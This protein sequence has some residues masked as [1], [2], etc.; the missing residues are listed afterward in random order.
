LCSVPGDQGVLS[1]HKLNISVSS[2]S[3]PV[4]E[5]PEGVHARGGQ[6]AG[7]VVYV[8]D[9]Y[10]KR[11]ATAPMILTLP[12]FYDGETLL[13]FYPFEMSAWIWRPKENCK[14]P[15]WDYVEV[16][17]HGGRGNNFM[18]AESYIK[19]PFKITSGTC[20]YAIPYHAY[21]YYFRV[22]FT[23][24]KSKNE[25]FL[26]PFEEGEFV[27][28][29][30][31]PTLWSTPPVRHQRDPNGGAAAA[32]PHDLVQGSFPSEVG[33]CAPP[34][35]PMMDLPALV[36]ASAEIQNPQAIRKAGGM[37][38]TTASCMTAP[39][40]ECPPSPD[41]SGFLPELVYL[42]PPPSP[43]MDPPARVPASAEIQSPQA[44]REAGGMEA[45]TASCMTAPTT[46]FPTSPDSSGV[47][48]ELG[49]LVPPPLPTMDPPARVSAS[50][51]IQNTGSAPLRVEARPA[52]S[53][54]KR[55]GLQ[56]E[57]QTPAG[58][59]KR[60][61]RP[62]SPTAADAYAL[63]GEIVER[64]ERGNPFG[65]ITLQPISHQN[66]LM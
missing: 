53:S 16:C 45:T 24:K 36:S 41:F 22:D 54:A 11:T 20:I 18:V 65:E 17:P 52:S 63:L 12:R 34:P 47:L 58:S 32:A 8:P 4:Q 25:L 27:S 33:Q 44:I 57:M 29:D 38:A 30:Q 26:M 3:L 19:F 14:P 39:T 1:K 61:K 35:S 23:S 2:D 62:A 42:V 31:P 55:S 9:V 5:F 15:G 49:H 51:E 48:P 46:E 21:H 50:A 40:T 56:R 28:P 7:K 13:K 6:R 60:V 43:M 64:M 59:E 37:E 10:N 66:Y